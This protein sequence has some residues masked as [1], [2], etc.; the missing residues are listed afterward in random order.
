MGGT[1]YARDAPPGSIIN[2]E[3]FKSPKH[4]A[5][6]LKELDNDCVAYNEY[7][8]WKHKYK[9]VSVKE[10]FKE[11]FCKLCEVLNDPNFENKTYVDIDSW[12]GKHEF[13]DINKHRS[14]LKTW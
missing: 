4:L 1:D 10:S 2:I 7:F 9:I 14:I 5:D 6:Y 11:G 13:C 8:K 12:W 3:D